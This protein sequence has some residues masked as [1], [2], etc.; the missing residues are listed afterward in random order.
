[1]LINLEI[2]HRQCIE[3]KTPDE[4]KDFIASLR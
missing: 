4:M 3:E 2:W 1:M